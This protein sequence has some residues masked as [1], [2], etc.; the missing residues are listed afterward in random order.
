MQDYEFTNSV[1][2]LLN[3]AGMAIGV[4]F[5]ERIRSHGISLPMYRVLA[6]LRQTGC[7]NLV[8]AVANHRPNAE[9]GF[10]YT[11]SSA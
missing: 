1:P 11:R 6:V 2:Y 4:R 5:T 10:G 8:L 9:K 3:R 7:K